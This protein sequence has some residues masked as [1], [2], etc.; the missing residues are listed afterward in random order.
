MTANETFLIQMCDAAKA[1][2]HLF[3]EYA[4]C[5]GAIE[6]GWGSSE[7]FKQGWNVFGNK[8]SAKPVYQTLSMPT[9]EVVNGRRVNIVAN[10]IKFPDLATAF[11]YRM[12]TLKRLM[13][14]YRDA[15]NATT[16]ENFVRNV[17][18]Q[19]AAADGPI[20]PTKYIYE[21]SDGI[22][23]W[24]KPRWATDPLRAS[25]VLQTYNAHKAIF[26]ASAV[27]T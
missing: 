23:Q 11:T 25:K 2:N 22:H 16:G 26:D 9:W 13:G 27:T 24:L 7:S 19:F 15:L 6:T 8:Q 10:F 20:D 5:E 14:I 4:A 17:S 3:P 1:A 18:G 21:F 12:D